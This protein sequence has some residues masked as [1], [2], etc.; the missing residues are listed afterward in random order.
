MVTL[1]VQETVFEMPGMDHN[2]TKRR[3]RQFF[4]AE[5]D[6][7]SDSP[8]QRELPSSDAHLK[9]AEVGRA[10]HKQQRYALEESDSDAGCGVIFMFLI[11]GALLFGVVVFVALQHS[12]EAHHHDPDVPEIHTMTPEAA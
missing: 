1:P 12:P 2:L 5:S 3:L 7:D 9:L 10:T 4:A 11:M 6:S 8:S